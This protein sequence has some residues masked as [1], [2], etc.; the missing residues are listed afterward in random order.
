M[1]FIDLLAGDTK[2]LNLL[3]KAENI[4]QKIK[5][6]PSNRKNIE[7]ENKS[8]WNDLEPFVNWLER[9]AEITQILVDENDYSKRKDLIEKYSSHWVK[10]KPLLKKLSHHKC[11]YSEAKEIFSHYHVE[12]F[13]P[14]KKAISIDGKDEGGYWWLAF[15]WRNYRLCGSVGNTKKGDK[16]P[17]KKGKWQTPN[18][19]IDPEIIYLLD[20]I[21]SDDP[22]ML[23]FT[24]DGK[25]QPLETNKDNFDYLRVKTTIETLDLNYDD[26]V[27][28]RKIV[29]QKCIH[30]IKEMETLTLKCNENPS[31][32]NLTLC[33]KL[34]EEL[35][36]C[37]SP[38]NEL[39]LVYKVCLESSGHSWVKKIINPN[40][41]YTKYCTCP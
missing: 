14:K 6:N 5:A 15:D 13:R 26:L 39:S 25:A 41:D 28:A 17:V 24:H 34:G 8:D 3:R 2:D 27:E 35:R 4:V 38:C 9:A 16:F 10:M 33:K 23:T 32:S 22:P 21:D 12:H 37:V 40:I 20:P 30:K 31:I 18:D 1:I 7:S 29:W 19:M 11:W 36:S